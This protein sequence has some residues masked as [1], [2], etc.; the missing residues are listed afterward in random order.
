[1]TAPAV[2]ALP[3]VPT[4]ISATDDTTRQEYIN[5][6]NKT[7]GALEQRGGVNLWNVASQFFNPGQ[8]GR[9]HV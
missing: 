8:I 2:G 7:L 5:A 3:A 1:M 4:G 6:L 9:A